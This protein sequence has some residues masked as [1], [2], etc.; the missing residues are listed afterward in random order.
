MRM[1]P[2]SA[3]VECMCFASVAAAVGVV[4]FCKR[5]LQL[6]LEVVRFHR[7]R[8]QR[9]GG[10]QGWEGFHAFQRP[11]GGVFQKALDVLRGE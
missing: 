2:P 1:I 6:P 11:G 5:L 7:C 8:R 4:V 10:G 9:R 3:A